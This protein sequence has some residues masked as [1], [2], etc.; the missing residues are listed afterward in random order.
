MP[1]QWEESIPLGYSGR[2]PV[3]IDPPQ[4]LSKPEPGDCCG[5]GC[6]NCVYDLYE[7]ALERYA[8]QLAQW[9]AAQG[10]PPKTGSG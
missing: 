8:L 2:M 10:L 4:P 6:V 9:R 1:D 3:S 5:G 7:T